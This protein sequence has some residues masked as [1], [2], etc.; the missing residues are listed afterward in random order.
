M[1]D[2]I[3]DEEA[4][5]TALDVNDIDETLV[6]RIQYGATMALVDA[7]D[8]KATHQNFVQIAQACLGLYGYAGKL[9]VVASVRNAYRN[10]ML[11]DENLAVSVENAKTLAEHSR[12]D[13]LA[14]ARLLKQCPL[15]TDKVH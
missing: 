5:I 7:Y 12:Q 1:S 10:G 4:I 9:Q 14:I 6:A 11:N 15:S 3:F 2:P 8:R 13:V